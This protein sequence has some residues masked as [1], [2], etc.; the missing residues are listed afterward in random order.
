MEKVI[1]ASGN[2]VKINSVKNGFTRMFPDMKFAVRGIKFQSPVNEQPIGDDETLR[3]ADARARQA[4]VLEPQAD[5][6][7]GIEGGVDG[8]AEE[9]AT[10]AWV[11]VYSRSNRGIARTA[12][13]FLPQEVAA[14]VASGKELG[15]ADDIFFGRTNSKQGNGAIGIL[16]ADVIDRQGLYEPAVIMALI[17]FKNPHLF[18]VEEQPSS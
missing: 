15:E 6:W 16:T 9:M 14:L 4:R 8:N 3:G 2:P 13:F 17:P 1:V 10:F 12:A 7:V 5:Y 18:P 11:V